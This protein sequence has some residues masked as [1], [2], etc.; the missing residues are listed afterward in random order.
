M[1]EIPY[2][3]TAYSLPHAMGYLPTKAGE[4]AARPLTPVNL[5]EAAAEMGL[6]G[7][8]V[9]LSRVTPVFD[10]KTV[11][12]E[13]SLEEL[14]ARLDA[15]GMHLVADYGI[16]MDQPAEH[17]HEY[18]RLAAQMGARV[19]RALLSNL[20]CGDRRKLDGGW[21][22]RLEAV[23]SRL[24][25]ALPL[26]EELGIAIAMENHQDAATAD[27]LRLHDMTGGSPA[28]G[29]TLDTGNP[30]SVGEDP[31]E[32][33][34]VLAPLIRHVHLKDYT[35]HFA[36]EGYRLVRC[37]AGAG[38]ID[39]PAILAAVRANGHAIV[40]GIEVAAQATRTIP[41]LE[42]GW[43]ECHPN[44]GASSLLGA[45]RILWEKGRPVDEPYSS[46][47]ERGADSPEVAAEEW[48]VVR[49]SVEYFR[50]LG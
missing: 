9:P 29:I 15:R 16:L 8:E 43:W 23:A 35:I 27:M 48:D 39:F 36:P 32:T 17:F 41:I 31:V 38:V 49:K 28:F 11:E 22:T 50:A 13:W 26:A 1:H 37:P 40:P 2:V 5:V 30:L 19:V 6:A 4:R 18:L 42:P 33:A 12:Q 47:W 10:G 44:R 20:L 24:R 7:V 46:G 21:E 34:R 25:M 3:L 45:L 14:R